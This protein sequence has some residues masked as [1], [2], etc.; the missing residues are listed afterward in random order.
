[1]RGL[2]NQYRAT[3]SALVVTI[4]LGAIAGA[5]AQQSPSTPPAA[6]E[7][8]SPASP[9]AQAPASSNK[10][11]EIVVTAPKPK[12]PARL[13]R[14]AARAGQPA[15]QT[16]PSQVSTAP[17]TSEASA[18]NTPPLQQTAA[19]D[20]T[21]T[22]LGDLPQSVVIVP[23]SVV[24]EQ[25]GT[26][27][28]DAVRDVSGV[29]LGGSSSYGFFD[30]FTIRGMDA[31]VYSDGF[32]DGD[33]FNGFAHSINGVQSIEVLKGPGSALFGSTTPGGSID[34]IHF[35]PSAVPGYGI[36]EQIGSYGSWMTSV[37]A[38]GPTTIPGLTYRVDGLFQHSDGFRDIASGNYELRPEWSWKHDNHVTT[39]ALDARRIDR[40]TDSYGI[41]YFNGTGNAGTPLTSVPNTAHYS[42]PFGYGDQTMERAT[43]VDSWWLADYLTI[44]NRLAFTHRDVDILRNS[45][46]GTITL[47]GGLFEEG[48]TGC[49]SPTASGCR[50]LREQTD[51]DDDFVYQFEPVWKFHTGSVG[52]TLLTGAQVEWQSIDDNRLTANLPNIA[53]IYAPVIPETSTNGLTFMRT[54]ALPGMQDQLRAL[55]LSAYTT[56]QIDVTDD[57]K[58]R[59]GVRQE[60]WYEELTPLAYVAQSATNPAPGRFEQNGTPL[61]PGV[62]DTEV[63]TP[64]SWSVGTLYKILPGVAPFAGVSKS[65]LTNFNSETTQNGVYAPE[66]GLEYEA[67]IKFST[68]DGRLVFMPAAF[69]IYRTNVF[70]ENT[71]TDTISFNAQNSRGV[72]ADV[73]FAITPQWKLMANAIAQNAV[74]TAVP[75]TP[76]QVG[77]WPVGVPRYIFNTWM[78]YDFAINGIHGFRVG[79]GLSFNSKT[80]AN[81]GNTSW[82]PDSTVIDTMFGYFAKNWDAQI[83]IK[84]I[85][86]V[87]Y[88]TFAESAGG[89]VGTPRT[90]YVKASWHY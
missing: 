31:R 53:N 15:G 17:A 24:T 42:T 86:N 58:V 33:Q 82:I 76:S 16:A 48:N 10:V 29:N 71:T 27:L 37:Y 89:Y 65:Y 11:P 23:R 83:G 77:N 51:H 64:T 70:T 6:P 43:A 78:T 8:S 2:G 20:K 45:G 21:G 5:H 90:Y 59:L 40:T 36:T 19:S 1:M 66:S 44:N 52:H 3:V 32:P 79:G 47:A 63:D 49:P 72:D 75:G 88:F 7:P 69:A 73:Q 30:R 84:N 12:P 28:S 46:G 9:A 39:V 85:A 57:W 35:L 25:G 87:E 14:R 41:L 26:S 81:S 50:Q 55:Y 22:K 38:T 61:E 56:D 18:A 60:H 4:G 62:V 80:Y 13:R 67:G 34:I 68:P 74:L 54:A